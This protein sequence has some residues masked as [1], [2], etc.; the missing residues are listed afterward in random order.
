MQSKRELVIV[1]HGMVAHRLVEALRAR[2]DE[3]R[4]HVTVLSEETDAA[5]DRVGLTAYT[6][7]WDRRALALAGNDYAGDESVQLHLGAVVT[8][9]NRADKVVSTAVMSTAPGRRF[10]YDALVLATGSYAFVPPVP[11]HDLPGCHVYRTLDDLD[12]I[13]ADV[14]AAL[15]A[16]HT[17]AGVVIGGGLLG[18]EAANALR[19]F[20]IEA[21]VVERA[22]R[23]M[24]QQLD[25]A[26]GALLGRMISELGIAV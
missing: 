26:G 3:N 1:G 24:A 16:G 4:W 9:I 13:K 19:S 11:G 7:H 21:H 25:E 14:A 18:L 22:P 15:T 17:R 23:L 5:Y 10:G 20:G 12:G 8:E 6:D 2:D